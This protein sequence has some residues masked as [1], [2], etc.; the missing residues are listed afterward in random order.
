MFLCINMLYRQCINGKILLYCPKNRTRNIAL[1]LLYIFFCV[2]YNFG[3][4]KI[5]KNK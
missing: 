5:A 3:I 2:L 4:K 1:L